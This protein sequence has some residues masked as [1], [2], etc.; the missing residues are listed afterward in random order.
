MSAAGRVF[1]AQEIARAL[2]KN[3]YARVSQ[4]GSHIKF[5]KMTTMIILQD[6]QG[7]HISYGLGCAILKK[8][9]IDPASV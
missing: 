5:K 9:G 7:K 1:K 3:G 6:H 2:E 4:R 8:A